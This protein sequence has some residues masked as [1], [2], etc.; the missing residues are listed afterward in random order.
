MFPHVRSYYAQMGVSEV[1]PPS[2]NLVTNIHFGDYTYLP[3]LVIWSIQKDSPYLDCSV[4]I[5]IATQTSTGDTSSCT[6]DSRA[7]SQS[8]T[9][10]GEVIRQ[11]STDGRTFNCR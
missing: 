8:H 10:S 3:P 2:T 7:L 9:E 4:E 6:P 11:E 1:I 5:P